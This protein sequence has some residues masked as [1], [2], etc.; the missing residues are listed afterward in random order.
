MRVFGEIKARPRNRQM[1]CAYYVET[2]GSGA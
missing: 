1:L 2:A